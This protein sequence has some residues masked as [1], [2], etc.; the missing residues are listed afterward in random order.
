MKLIVGLGNP[1]KEYEKTR[2][3]AGFMALD[4]FAEAKNCDFK[5]EKKFLG[6]TARFDDVLLLK[7]MI[8]MNNSG[9]SV[10]KIMK[11]YKIQP[12]D[13][14]IVYDD[15]DMI[16]EKLRYRES[17][18]SGGHRGMQSIIDSLGENEIPRIKIGLDSPMRIKNKLTTA[19]FV[20]KNFSRAELK[21][22]KTLLLEANEMIDE[23][24]IS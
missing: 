16:F 4:S 2:H 8:F 12:K 9:N 23:W 20:L 24:L 22:L 6:Q 19:D 3:N 10:A 18:S 14:L 1:G 5:D 7:P 17:G 13:V 11:F 21:T 15:K